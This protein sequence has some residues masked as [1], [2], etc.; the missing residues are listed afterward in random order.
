MKKELIAE[1]FKK[2]EDACYAM[3]GLECWSGRDL[4]NILG[5]SDWRNFTN[6]IQKA[7]K[8]CVLRILYFIR[9]YLYP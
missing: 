1:L 9:Q 8:A 3:E 2:F 7:I 5:Y 4:Q 6:I